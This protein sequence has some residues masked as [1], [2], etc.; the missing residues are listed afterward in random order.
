[1]FRKIESEKEFLLLNRTH[2]LVPRDQQNVIYD[3]EARQVAQLFGTP[4]DSFGVEYR[5][6]FYVAQTFYGSAMDNTLPF[7]NDAIFG[8]LF[9]NLT[10][11]VTFH[12]SAIWAHCIETLLNSIDSPGM[13][14]YA[15]N[16]L[17]VRYTIYDREFGGHAYKDRAEF[18]DKFAK[19]RLIV[20]RRLAKYGEEH[21]PGNEAQFA[22]VLHESFERLPPHSIYRQNALM[23]IEMSPNLQVTLEGV[24]PPPSSELNDLV[25][26]LLHEIAHFG[27]DIYVPLLSRS[28]VNEALWKIDF[29][30]NPNQSPPKQ[31]KF[32]KLHVNVILRKLREHFDRLLPTD[33]K[34]AVAQQKQQILNY[35]DVNRRFPSEL[36]T[37]KLLAF[38]SKDAHDF[39]MRVKKIQPRVN[40][41]D[42]EMLR[43]RIELNELKE[44]LHGRSS[45]ELE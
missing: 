32:M 25:K 9:S 21:K 15:E 26:M 27:E 3:L 41:I 43:L 17:H 5:D 2:F 37:L 10:Q 8:R 22:R 33:L 14:F 31:N 36:D 35:F 4:D 23:F 40:E 30:T 1:M 24:A 34:D 28:Q 12:P 42:V 18:A 29:P 11:H 6:Q 38:D 13:V 44:F 16:G 45:M 39:L 19:N 7:V 20:A